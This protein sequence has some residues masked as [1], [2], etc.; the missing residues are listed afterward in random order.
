MAIRK[1]ILKCIYNGHYYSV[2]SKDVCQQTSTLTY[3]RT[4]SGDVY[5]GQKS[6]DKNWKPEE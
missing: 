1:I 2:D 4:V 5:R 3:N 6:H